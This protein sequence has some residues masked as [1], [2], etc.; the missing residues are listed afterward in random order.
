MDIILIHGLGR[1]PLSMLLLHR[2][3]KQ[4]GYKP[5][6][7]GYSPTFESLQRTANRLTRLIDQKIGTNPYALVGHSLGSV[8]IRHT[9]PQLT[10]NPPTACFFLAPPM[11]ACKA[12]HYFSKFP[13]LRIAGGEMAT[14]LT[15]DDFMA[16]LTMPAN[17]KIYVGTRGPRAPWFPL[18]DEPNDCVLSLSEATGPYADEATLV[19]AVHTFIMNSEQ[20]LNDIH[21]TLKEMGREPYNV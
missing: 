11:V 19:P 20:V 9:Q 16:Q 10:E 2:R 1:T 21:Q 18:G 14:L 4:Y 13:P 3:L 7:F 8:I 6:I 15:Q 5:H 12:A 17:T